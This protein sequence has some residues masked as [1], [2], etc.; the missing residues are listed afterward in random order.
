MADFDNLK[1]VSDNFNL[2]NAIIG[3]TAQQA[4]IVRVEDWVSAKPIGAGGKLYPAFTKPIGALLEY[5]SQRYIPDGTSSSHTFEKKKG[6]SSETSVSTEVKASVGVNILGCDASM[7]VTT[8]FTYTQGISSETTESWTD[9]V[10]GPATFYVY[11]AVLVYCTR[12]TANN[13]TRAALSVG[14]TSYVE[15]NGEF[16]FL[17]LVFKDSPET[18]DESIQPVNEQDFNAY[19]LNAGWGRWYT[20][21]VI[22]GKGHLR[23]AGSD[24]YAVAK[25]STGGGGNGNPLVLWD[26]YGSQAPSG[27]DYNTFVLANDGHL[28]H[29]GSGK[30]VVADDSTGGGGNG[31][32]LVLWDS[33]GSQ[34]PSGDDYNKFV[35]TQDGHLYHQGSG[36][37]V[38]AKNS[39]GGGGNGNPLVLWD[40]Y[41]SQTAL[42][43]AY[44][45]FR[46]DGA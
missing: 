13:D 9:T 21:L 8:G 43:D 35:L 45:E 10:T 23:H 29:Q 41:G 42:G 31:N 39:T 32:T 34:A 15:R 28:Y 11:Q 36:K 19:L 40:G 30:Y 4:C 17:A 6:Y 3:K 16:F 25:D 2:D 26:G 38:V 7:E 44:N 18:L 27:N 22:K 14:N 46:F 24:K 12:V 5:I 20:D 37:Y 33:Y 1:T